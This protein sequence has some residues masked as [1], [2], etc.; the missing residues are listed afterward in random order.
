MTSTAFAPSAIHARVD[1]KTSLATAAGR[2]LIAAGA[3]FGSA[4]LI[5]W[6]IMSG[7]LHVSPALLSLVWPVAVGLFLVVLRRLRRHGGDAARRTA[8]W[9]RL[10]ILAQ[11]VAALSLAGLSAITGHWA[12]MMWISV[13]GL[14]IYGLAWSIAAFRTRRAWIGVMAVACLGAAGGVALLVGAPAQYLAYGCSLIVFALVPGL[15]LV[16]RGRI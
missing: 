2:T 13:A 6:G 7:V 14:A 10:A 15:V 3:A 8:V 11:V 9:S 4:N 12:L 5:Q 16:F 1:H